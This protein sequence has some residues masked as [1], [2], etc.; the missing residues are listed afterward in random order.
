M[1]ITVAQLNYH[2][3][4]CEGNKNLILKAIGKA[5]NDGSDL[6]IFSELCIPGYPPL[7][8]LHR[9]DFIEKCNRIV[10]EIA[11]H[12]NG[13][14]AIAGSPVINKNPHGKKLFN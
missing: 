14:A 12:C 13:I 4:N 2:I 1:K 6:V 8:L 5:K 7:D 10:N 3:G 11:N 9:A